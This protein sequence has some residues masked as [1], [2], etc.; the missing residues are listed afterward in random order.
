MELELIEPNVFL[1][2]AEG[3]ADRFA[4]AIARRLR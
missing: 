4:A 1:S 3:S 2:C